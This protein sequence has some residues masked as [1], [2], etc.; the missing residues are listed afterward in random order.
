MNKRKLESNLSHVARILPSDPKY[1][2]LLIFVFLFDFINIFQTHFSNFLFCGT[3]CR[4]LKR[5]GNNK[6]KCLLPF[7]D[8]SL[9]KIHDM[10][11]R[12]SC[13]HVWRGNLKMGILYFE[14][15]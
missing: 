9:I 6:I 2:F 1:T 10:E 15:L 11:R 12:V 8:L 7:L 14:V 3:Y 5:E 4:I 13:I